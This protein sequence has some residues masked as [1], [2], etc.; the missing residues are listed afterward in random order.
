MKP[1]RNQPML[2]TVTGLSDMTQLIGLRGVQRKTIEEP[3][4]V[5]LNVGVIQ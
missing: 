3:C 4:K 5:K 2:S 1:A